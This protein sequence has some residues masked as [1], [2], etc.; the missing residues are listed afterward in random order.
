MFIACPSLIAPIASPRLYR[1]ICVTDLDGDGH[2][3]IL[4]ASPE[5]PGRLLKWNGQELADGG[6]PT[7]VASPTA[8]FIAADLDGDGREEVY[9][10][11]AGKDADGPDSLYG[12]D[13]LFTGFG[14]RWLDLLAL[15]ENFPVANRAGGTVLAV[16]DRLGQG[17]YG[18]LV[19]PPGEALR[20]YELDGR[21]RLRDMA[22]EAGLDIVADARTALALPLLGSPMTDRG[23]DLFLGC[24]N[25]PNLLFRNMGNGTFEE[26]ASPWGVAD[27]RQQSQAAAA[28]DA[29]G[30]GLFDLMLGT[31]DG[32][33]RLFLQRPGGGFADAAPLEMID[34]SRMRTAIA[35]DFD[36]DGYEELLLL[37]ADRPNRL[38]A[39]RD[40]RWQESDAGD[41]GLA[42]A[43][44][45]AVADI[46]GD[47]QLEL[48]LSH[49]ADAPHPVSLHLPEPR[50]HHWLRVRPLTR[51]GAPARGA[52]VRLT[53]DGRTQSRVICGGSGQLCQMEPVAHFG[54]GPA[55]A[56]TR[57][58]V[59]WPDGAASVLDH[60]HPC[61]TL[62]IRHP[63]A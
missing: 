35:A 29:D 30:D 7:P 53:A 6:Q 47:G 15:P 17:R 49:G 32:H 1:G 36:N 48:I 5:G 13:R 46:D 57:V 60:P 59:R 28:L 50:G 33:H 43:H 56:V 55:R 37:N 44:G 23:P 16:L 11:G 24:R 27:S 52:V 41:A 34:P 62:T 2:D 31:W 54:L 42:V 39:W 9:A 45:A 20:L 8:A 26:L 63:E 25:G 3:E 12:P 61:R 4:V 19:A 40:E 10:L 14:T 18:I 51:A 58:E 21:G 38:F 22:E